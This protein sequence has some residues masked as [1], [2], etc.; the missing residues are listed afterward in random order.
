VVH[1]NSC[2]FFVDLLV[3]IAFI[4]VVPQDSISDNNKIDETIAATFFYRLFGKS[5][6]IVRIFTALVVL[7]VIGTAAAGVWR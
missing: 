2:I 7:S 6:V 4:S 5:V 1:S 3:N